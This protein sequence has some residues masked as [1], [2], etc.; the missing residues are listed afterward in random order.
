MATTNYS[1]SD[2]LVTPAAL[3]ERYGNFGRTFKSFAEAEL[4]KVTHPR[5]I[6]TKLINYNS[7]QLESTGSP[8]KPKAGAKPTTIGYLVTLPESWVNDYRHL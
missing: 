7:M 1:I 5:S 6:I 4:F 2:S 8:P 3:N